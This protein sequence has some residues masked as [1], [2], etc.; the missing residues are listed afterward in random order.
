MLLEVLVYVVVVVVVSSGIIMVHIDISI[1]W[2]VCKLLIHS[3]G[4]TSSDATCLVRPRLL[5]TTSP[6][7]LNLISRERKQ[8]LTL[9]LICFPLTLKQKLRTFAFYGLADLIRLVES[10]A[11][12]YSL[13]GGAVGGGCSG[14]G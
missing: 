13:Q 3:D 8:K 12:G 1:S 9:N 10:A 4:T 7:T 2:H 11:F 14:L 6:K 5:C